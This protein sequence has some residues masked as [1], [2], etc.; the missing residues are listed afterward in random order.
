MTQQ[1]EAPDFSVGEDPANLLIRVDSGKYMETVYGYGEMV[2]NESTKTLD[3]TVHISPLVV[4][5]IQ[6]DVGAMLPVEIE[7]FYKVVAT[8]IIEDLRRELLETTPQ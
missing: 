5:G 6:R 4:N 8:P 2:Y 1:I 7:D 3:Y